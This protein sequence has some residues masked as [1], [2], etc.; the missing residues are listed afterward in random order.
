MCGMLFGVND[1]FLVCFFFFFGVIKNRQNKSS[2]YRVGVKKFPTPGIQQ[3]QQK[4]NDVWSSF[5]EKI[6]IKKNYFV[7]LCVQNIQQILK[8]IQKFLIWCICRGSSH[9]LLIIAGFAFHCSI[10]FE[11]CDFL[12]SPYLNQSGYFHREAGIR[13]ITNNFQQ[14][15]ISV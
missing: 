11:K 10:S 3:Q 6:E 5:L 2:V 7:L 1:E 4:H 13:K 8:N 15:L 14:N 9:L 12:F